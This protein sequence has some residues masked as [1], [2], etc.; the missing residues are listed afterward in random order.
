M[1]LLINGDAPKRPALRW[2][3]GKWKLAKWIMSYFPP[4]TCYCEPFGGAAS[5]LLRKSPAKI[6]VYNDC[7]S[8]VVNFFQVLREHPAELIAAIDLTPYSREEFRL[9]QIP[10]DDPLEAA[11]RFYVWSWQ[12][13]GRGGVEEPGGWRFMSRDTRGKTPV[14]DW[15]NYEH[16]WAVVRRLKNVQIE[17]ADAL[18][19]IKR[20]DTSET[21]FYVDPPY[22][23]SS[24]GKRW[25]DAAYKFEFTDEQHR[26]LASILASVKGYVVL[27]GYPSELYSELYNGWPHFEKPGEKDNEEPG[28]NPVE[29]LWLSPRTL[30]A[31][32]E[33]AGLPLFGG[34]GKE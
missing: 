23:Q 7:L 5:V 18:S 9:A 29:I 22:I 15:N 31:L 32:Q 33:G 11:R 25:S 6:E 20:F 17:N 28:C 16:L 10:V 3:G 24:R 26:E 30:N 2:H 21:L 12:G 34:N 8:L 14:D 19:V 13:R 4:H 1:I 27:S